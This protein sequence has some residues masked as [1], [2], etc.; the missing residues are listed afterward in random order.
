VCGG[1]WAAMST[2]VS[3]WHAYI[4]DRLISASLIA[5]QSP[6]SN[7]IDIRALQRLPDAIS[8]YCPT[9]FSGQGAT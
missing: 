6:E 3:E 7:W 8:S 4:I 1:A 2:L 5:F 9:A